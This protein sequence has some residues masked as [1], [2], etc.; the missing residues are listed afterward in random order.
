[1][2]SLE[3]LTDDL[4]R[5]RLRYAYL[6]AAKYSQDPLTNV[7]A[8][9]APAAPFSSWVS[10]ANTFPAGAT[11]TPERQQRPLIHDY[12]VH[13][14]EA[15]ILSAASRHNISTAGATMY[16]PW[17]SCLRCARQ[18]IQSGIARLVR[19][20]EMMDRTYGKWG[21]EI[22]KA[23]AM[24]IEAGVEIVTWSG[25]VGECSHLMNGETWSP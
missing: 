8:V 7:G 23:D 12:I 9:I 21:E 10:G 20:K 1:M 4:I 2:P 19:H 18:I 13:G 22:A 3:V 24:M 14:E 11:V 5:E 25:K 17:A 16:A 15:A 6:V